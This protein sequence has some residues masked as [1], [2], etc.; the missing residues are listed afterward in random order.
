LN[1]GVGTSRSDETYVDINGDGLPGKV[2]AS[3]A[4]AGAA[5]TATGFTNPIPAGRQGNVAVDKH[6]PLG[7]ACSS[8]SASR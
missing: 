3:S 6:I 1:L 8:R 5:H 2:I 4:P 7:G